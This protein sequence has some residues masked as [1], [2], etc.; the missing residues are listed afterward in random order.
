M[1]MPDYSHSFLTEHVR[2]S[3]ELKFS[4][5]GVCAGFSAASELYFLS[6]K[7]EYGIF[8]QIDEYLA[9]EESQ[10]QMSA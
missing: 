6:G 10:L 8:K 5:S 1:L 9:G 7:V 3:T 4:I 2:Q